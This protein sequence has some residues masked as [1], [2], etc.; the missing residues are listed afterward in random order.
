MMTFLLIAAA[1]AMTFTADRIAADN[2]THALAATGHVVAV[3]E[4]LTIRG[5]YMTRDSDGVM[6]FHDPVCATTCTND[7]GHTHWNVTGDVEYKADDHVILRNAWLRFYEIPIFWM[8]YLYY[9]LDTDCGFRFMPGYIGRWGAYLLT[10]YSY[11]LLGDS[12]NRDN[13]WWL[14][15]ATRFDLRYRQGVAL[16][17]DLT[18]NLGDFGAGGL[19]IYY[20]WDNDIDDYEVG[21]RG[22]DHDLNWGSQVGHDRYSISAKHRWEMTERDTVRVSALYL[23]DSFFLD[24][25]RRETMFNW[26][27][28]WMTYANSGL[29]WEH[30][31]N[32][33]AFGAE[34]SGRLNKFYG[35]TDRL[36]EIY[37][38]VH[39]LPVFGLPVN[40]ETENRI[41]YL[42]RHPAEYGFGDRG[43]PFAYAPGIWA[44]Y[45]TLRFDTYHRL[46]S[47]FKVFDDVLAVVPRLGYHGTYWNQG[48]KEILS[49]WNE[50]EEVNAMYRSVLEGGITFAGRGTAWVN[51]TW[52][53]MVEP[54]FDILAQEAW[55]AGADGRPYFFD[56]IDGSTIWE[57]QFA[58]RSRNLPY[59]YYG[60]TP[61]WRNAWERLDDHGVL[62]KVIDFDVYAAL[63]FCRTSFC[64]DSD[65]HKLAELGRPNYGK[66]DCYVSPGARLR[67][68][69]SDKMELGGAAEYDPDYN[70]IA[71]ADISFRHELSKT[72]KYDVM[73]ALRDYRYWD[74]SSTP[75]PETQPALEDLNYA[76]F[77]SVRVGFENQ[78]L[79]WF[80][81]GPYVRWDLQ[82]NELD[83]IGSWFDYLTDC[84]GF[85]VILEYQNSY[86]RIDGYEHEDDWSIGF[87]IYLRAFGADSANLF[88]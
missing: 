64:G 49:G 71:T 17:E 75:T 63:Q 47:P 74:F 40:Y 41:G 58:G 73:Y 55:Y 1:Q 33:L 84:L 21:D 59:S 54:Y 86:T 67:W 79:D 57:D 53:H 43:N 6:H 38:D 48:G 4:P 66:K 60:V 13:T 77:H 18:W 8:P 81:W 56:N 88:R 51:D 28:Q 14:D 32:A 11:H 50:S 24:D 36:P 16:G 46:T 76:K 42:V 9:P 7:V 61:G 72:F 69:P 3:S 37:L 30:I 82:E 70:H 39:P 45:E 15:G 52:R 31:E 19:N 68:M 85:R 35:M 23:S 12:R 44:D 10:M 27:G 34:A 78:P 62:R 5:E 2:V 87:Y 26:K 25:Y 20:A 83:G 80:A 65:A 29:F 22:F